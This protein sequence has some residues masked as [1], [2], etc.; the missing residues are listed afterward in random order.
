[1]KD[2]ELHILDTSLG[3]LQGL[4]RESCYVYL[5]VPYAKAGRFEYARPAEGWDGVFDAAKPGNACP[6]YRQVDPKLDDPERW[7]YHREFR[8]GL[9]FTYDEDCLNLNIY[10]PK[11]AENCPVIVFIHGGGFNS[12]SNSEQPF[13][14][15]GLAARGIV[16]VFINYR[17]GV[18]GYLTHSEVQERFGRDGNFALDDQLTAVKWVKARIADFGGDPEN[19][20]LMGQSAGA[21]SIQY[22]CLDKK[23]RGLFRRAVM[24]SGG[25]C[26]PKFALPKKAE[27]ARSYWL[28]LMEEAGC[29]SLDELKNL[30]AEELLLAVERLKKRR[31]DSIFYTMPVVD[32][33]L[34]EAPVDRLI[35]DPLPV[36]YM[37]GYTNN[38]MYGPAMAF[39]GDRFGKANGAY[40][41]YFDIDSPGDGN[42]AFHSSDIRYALE[43]L[44]ESW[45]PYGPRDYEVSKELASYIANFAR[46]GDPNG[47]G[48]PIWLKAGRGPLAK[49]LHF[50]PGSTQMGRPDYAKLIRNMITKGA[51]KA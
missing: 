46:C 20:T 43:R 28:D 8:D 42:G 7:F 33:Y 49:V 12:G 19:I 50:A 6:Q 45:R 31:S 22:L 16:S 15:E 32:G 13:N 25:G 40:I 18:F 36:D 34:I 23:N 44:D 14:G 2:K 38:D 11:N 51:P 26:F 30:S 27:D 35:K 41:Y 4:E 3:R 1:M 37:I 24:M 17:V 48:L 29:A 47:G 5:G 9:S 21:I 39:I 10:T